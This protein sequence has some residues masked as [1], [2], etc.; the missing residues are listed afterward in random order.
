MS[1]RSVTSCDSLFVSHSDASE[2]RK[3]RENLPMW[4]VYALHRFLFNKEVRGDGLAWQLMYDEVDVDS[5]M[6]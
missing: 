3:T 1:H 2:M 4:N 5:V 6:S